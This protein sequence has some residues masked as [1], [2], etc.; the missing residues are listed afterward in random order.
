MFGTVV[1]TRVYRQMIG[2]DVKWSEDDEAK[3]V[4]DESHQY[5]GLEQTLQRAN[6]DYEHSKATFGKAKQALGDQEELIAKAF[7]DA[8]VTNADF[9]IDD[10]KL[11]EGL[12]AIQFEARSS[13]GN[14][15]GPEETIM[16]CYRVFQD[17]YIKMKTAEQDKESWMRRVNADRRLRKM[18]Q[19]QTAKT[20]ALTKENAA[21]KAAS[22]N[23][24]VCF[25]NFGH[26]EETFSAEF[27]SNIFR[28]KFFDSF[29]FEKSVWH[30]TSLRN[31]EFG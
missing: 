28:I 16:K 26:Q 1:L 13:A 12:D 3:L 24:M 31:G 21:L 2:S 4:A 5:K 30:V 19:L 22:A 23:S 6:T 18:I 11:K 8:Y 14:T 29:K 15:T 17:A 7:D 9:Q 20:E 25:F 27:H 10:A